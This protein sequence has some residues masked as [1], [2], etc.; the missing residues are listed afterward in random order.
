MLG[1]LKKSSRYGNK[2]ISKAQTHGSID[3]SLIGPDQH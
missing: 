1:R 3:D 2:G